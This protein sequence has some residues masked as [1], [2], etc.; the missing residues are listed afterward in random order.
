MPIYHVDNCHCHCHSPF[1]LRWG[2]PQGSAVGPL[3]FTLY[4][5]PPCDMISAHHGIQH[6][7]YA[8]DTQLYLVMRADV[9][10][11]RDA[12]SRVY[13]LFT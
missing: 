5:G 2:V 8:D 3:L 10:D 4:T 7:M 1:P 9:G 6:A 13:R 11:R 12:I